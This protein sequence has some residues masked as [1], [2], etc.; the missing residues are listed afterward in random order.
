MEFLLNITVG[1]I[2][3]AGIACLL[4]HDLYH[5]IS[6]LIANNDHPRSDP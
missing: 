5:R 6:A 1:Q 2:V 4:I 3:C